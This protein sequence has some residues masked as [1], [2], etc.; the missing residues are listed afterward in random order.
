MIALP[1]PPLA[2]IVTAAAVGAAEPLNADPPAPGA[3]LLGSGTLRHAHRRNR[4]LPD[5]SLLAA[6]A[7]CRGV[8]PG[9]HSRESLTREFACEEDSEPSE[10]IS[11][12]TEYRCVRS[13][14]RSR[15][16]P[17]SSAASVAGL[18]PTA[19]TPPHV[20][21][22]STSCDSVRARPRPKSARRSPLAPP[23]DPPL[24]VDGC[25]GVGSE[26]RRSGC[27]RSLRALPGAPCNER[28]R[29]VGLHRGAQ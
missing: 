29:R 21:M 23:P 10:P 11:I 16:K 5:C 4:V 20:T 25:T 17:D 26:W 1:V 6:P 24:V 9:E 8:P 19:G 14:S 18:L 12:S 28:P 27:G 15:W 22:S 2:A 7:A 3:Q 13:R